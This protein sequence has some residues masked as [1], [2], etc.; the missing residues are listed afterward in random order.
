MK[1]LRFLFPI[2]I[3]PIFVA[4]V[5]FS[6]VFQSCKKDDEPEPI[7]EEPKIESNEAFYGLMKEWYFWYDQIPEINPSSFP[8]PSALLEAIKKTPEDRWS[9][10]TSKQEFESYFVESKM[11][12]HGFSSR[13]DGQGKLRVAFLFTDSD[14]FTNGVERG[15]I[16]EAINGTVISPG[17]NFNT[18]LGPNQGGVTNTFRFRKPDGTLADISS[19]KK[20]I[21]MNNILHSEIIEKDG[22]KIGYMVLNGFTTPTIAE[23]D[24]VIAIFSQIN[25]DEMI[26][27]MRYNGGGQ[28]NVAAHLASKIAG[29]SISGQP[30]A[31]YVYN[32][33]KTAQNRIDNFRTVDNGLN[34]SR[35]IT[36]CT[37]STASAS[38]MVI[39]GL[40]PFIDVHI[41][42]NNTYGKPMGMNAWTYDDLAFVPITFKTKNANDFGDY[43][44]GLPANL[45][46]PDDLSKA[47]GD[48]LESSLQQALAFITT[49]ITKSM[50]ALETPYKQP[51]EYMT[52]LQAIIGAH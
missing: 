33:K 43:F 3:I 10:I 52:G 49:G 19:T 9:Y 37:R 4:F 28:T 21:R 2:N 39:N 13:Y 46:A 17:F 51:V 41:V 12:G 48:P 29:N 1:K 24:S 38:E 35:L 14:L 18:L 11:F 45:F 31:K 30:F 22:L 40:Q 20:E 34:L 32:D 27:D 5:L 8:N 25:I 26:L 50:P 36:I 15:W 7:D 16:I 44:E 6:L 47:F 42:G 23:I